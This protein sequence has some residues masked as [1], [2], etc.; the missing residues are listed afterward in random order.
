MREILGKNLV[1]ETKLENIKTNLGSMT[2]EGK[3]NAFKTIKYPKEQGS[4]A[5]ALDCIGYS[6]I[7]IAND[8]EKAIRTP[9]LYAVIAAGLFT[10]YFTRGVNMIAINEETVKNAALGGALLGGGGGGNPKEGEKLGELSLAVG[11]P[12]LIDLD[13][14]RDDAILVTVSAVGAPAAK[15]QHLKPMHYVK[16]IQLIEKAGVKVEGLITCE[17]G[18]LAT[19]N[20]WFQSAM[21]GIPVVDAPCNGRAHPTGSMGSMGLHKSKS[22]VSMQAAV[23]GDRN[24]GRYLEIYI[25]TNII[26]ASRIIRQTAISAG[27]L[28]GVARN[29]VTVKYA[30]ENSAVGGISQAIELGRI[31]REAKEKNPK[32]MIER[33]VEFLRGRKLM[34]GKIQNVK[35]KTIGGFDIGNATV[36]D[37]KELYELTFWNEYMCLEKEGQ[38]IGTFPDLIATI[39]LET[40]APLPTAEVKEGQSVAIL[41]IPRQELKLGSGMKDPEIFKQIEEITN[42]QI[43]KYS[44]SGGN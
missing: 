8:P 32:C 44:F 24:E 26:E 17:N 19:L 10:W 7:G 35:L 5:I 2:D 25:V 36:R 18:G 1:T 39:D 33:A 15:E 38:R 28:V 27:G 43:I 34:E 16:A 6:T 11:T 21:L 31:M 40:G 14:L 30:R 13:E 9:V 23:G 12:T 42:K 22:Y 41:H 3:R 20:G 29:P 37:E 4:E